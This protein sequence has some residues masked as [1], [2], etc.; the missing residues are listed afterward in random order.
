MIYLFELRASKKSVIGFMLA[1]FQILENGQIKRNV[2]RLKSRVSASLNNES[3]RSSALGTERDSNISISTNGDVQSN[4]SMNSLF[5]GSQP[6]QPIS[7]MP[8]FDAISEA[9]ESDIIDENENESL[10]NSEAASEQSEE[11]PTRTRK[12]R[13]GKRTRVN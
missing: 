12:P 8:N 10:P 1:V 13:S 5:P 9:G 2:I 6:L 4:S 11:K 7:Q 3:I